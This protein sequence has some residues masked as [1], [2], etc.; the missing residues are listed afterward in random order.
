MPSQI[1]IVKVTVVGADAG[2][3]KITDDFGNILATNVSRQQL[4]D[5]VSVSIDDAAQT[6]TVTS[7]GSKCSNT[8]SA[9]YSSGTGTTV[10]TIKAAST[11]DDL[12]NNRGETINVTSVPGLAY[13]VVGDV[14]KRY[15]S[16]TILTGYPYIAMYDTT[17]GKTTGTV[18]EINPSTGLVTG[19]T[20]IIIP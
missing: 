16:G 8:I 12:I 19:D 10:F 4:I 5:G 9:A 13:I 1:K 6:I 11:S 3:F 2:P 15:P 7:T 20:G 14:V 17:L 18:Y